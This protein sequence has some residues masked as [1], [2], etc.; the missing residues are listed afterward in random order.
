[1]E[2]TLN[3]FGQ[4]VNAKK[5]FQM[6]PRDESMEAYENVSQTFYEWRYAA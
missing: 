2:F 4:Q 1:M 6:P 3:I 5:I